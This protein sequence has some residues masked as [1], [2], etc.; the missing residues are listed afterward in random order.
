MTSFSNIGHTAPTSSHHILPSLEKY[1]RKLCKAC[2]LSC[3]NQVFIEIFSEQL[4][5][6]QFDYSTEIY[7][8]DNKIIQLIINEMINSTAYTL[9]GIAAQT[10]LPFEIVHNVAYGINNQLSNS[11][12]TRILWLYIEFNPAI[13][14]ILIKKLIGL[15]KNDE[16]IL[17]VLNEILMKP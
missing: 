3:L 4:K 15:K 13:V 17:S 12:W 2:L 5:Y 14:D 16:S 6:F 10:H 11:A 7:D 8:M 9:E 1:Q